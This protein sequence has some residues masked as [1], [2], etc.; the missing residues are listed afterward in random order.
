MFPT[1]ADVLTYAKGLKPKNLIGAA[2]GSYGWS[3]EATTHIEEYLRQMGVEL[4][5]PALRLKFVP[6]AA[7]LAQCREF[8][9]VIASKLRERVG[10]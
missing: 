9:Q 8:G 7:A 5:A 4:A 2:F 6:D 10:K 3:G 1:V